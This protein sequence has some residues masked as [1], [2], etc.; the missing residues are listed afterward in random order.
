MLQGIDYWAWLGTLYLVVLTW[1]DF[2][3]NMNVDD[4]KNYFMMGASFALLSHVQRNIW[5][6]LILILFTV[7]IN[8]YAKKYNILGHADISTL[9]WVFYGFGIINPFFLLFFILYFGGI[10]LLYLILKRVAL[11]LLK[12]PYET[13]TPFYIVILISFLSFGIIVGLY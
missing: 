8:I 2:R 5:Y 9:T 6:I 4:R 1:Q 10:T 13:P 11:K 12:R 7:L 3:N